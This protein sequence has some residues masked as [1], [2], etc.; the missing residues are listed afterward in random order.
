MSTKQNV[1]LKD[2][3]KTHIIELPSFSGSQIELYEGVLFGEAQRIEQLGSDI[4][5]GIESLLS[6]IK[7]WNFSDE[8]GNLV[9][10]NKENL[11]KLPA[12]D[13]AFLMNKIAEL[14]KFEEQKSKKV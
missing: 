4:E 3:R 1:V 8:D 9:E 10:I 13:L 7:S 14:M 12:N 11:N 5:K 2:V 6:M